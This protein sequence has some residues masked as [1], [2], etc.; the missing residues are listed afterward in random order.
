MSPRDLAMYMSDPGRYENL[1]ITEI[2]NTP[3]GSFFNGISPL[4]FIIEPSPSRNVHTERITSQHVFE[5]LWEKHLY[6][7]TSHL[8]YLYDLFWASPATAASA[9][10][11]FDFQMHQLIA[12]QQ[13]IWIFPITQGDSRSANYIY[14][15]Y[16]G[17][18]AV[19]LQLTGSQEP[20]AMEDGFTTNHYYRLQP[21][22]FL[23][24]DSLL[25]I[26][27]PNDSPPILLM[28]GIT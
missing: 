11:I 5:L 26:H 17:E 13:T 3:N 18:N 25:L 12:E 14:K 21:T 28:F 16:P 10:W 6:Y 1:I 20:L 9:G 4:I 22:N 19:D 2:S 15:D 23:T 24:I 7:L 27:P 8:G